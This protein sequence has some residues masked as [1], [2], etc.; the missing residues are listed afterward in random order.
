MSL[1]YFAD[2]SFFLRK[3]RENT[4]ISLMDV[5]SRTRIPFA[6]LD[7]IERGEFGFASSVLIQGYLRQYARIIGLDE[8]AVARQYNLILKK[9]DYVSSDHHLPPP[10]IDQ[11]NEPVAEQIR[12]SFRRSKKWIRRHYPIGRQ[13]SNDITAETINTGLLSYRVS[14]SLSETDKIID[15]EVARKWQAERRMTNLVTAFCICLLVLSFVF[16]LSE[17][18]GSESQ[19]N[20]T[21]ENAN[22]KKAPNVSQ[23]SKRLTATKKI[24]WDLTPALLTEEEILEKERVRKWLENDSLQ[25]RENLV[26]QYAQRNLPVRKISVHESVL[27]QEKNYY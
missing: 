6:Y 20:I 5:S 1:N 25:I 18:T 12:D 27:F 9:I 16:F 11:T 7:S 3:S 13:K 23:E 8:E 26:S 22:P 21:E 4:G 14:D 17:P 19:K 10:F 24:M 2:F 15:E